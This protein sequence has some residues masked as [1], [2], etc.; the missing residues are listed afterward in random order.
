MN[1]EQKKEVD[2]RLNEILSMI[3]KEVE[4]QNSLWGKQEYI[5]DDR[6]LEIA[7]DEFN[8]MKWAVRVCR[9]ENK[10]H[11][12]SHER[13]QLMAVLVRWALSKIGKQALAEMEK[14]KSQ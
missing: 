8:D 4:R 1:A 10:G 13:N 2:E 12:I 3:K 14:E 9:I 11:D 5:P 7:T 6:W